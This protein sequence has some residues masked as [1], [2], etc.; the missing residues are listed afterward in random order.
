MPPLPRVNV[1]AVTSKLTLGV[2]V[3]PLSVNV[4][5][6]VQVVQDIVPILLNVPAVYVAVL[7]HVK[8]KVAKS[9]VPAVC[10]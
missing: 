7:E 4:P 6:L 9:I 1:P 10:V 2:I 3:P 8:L 5:A